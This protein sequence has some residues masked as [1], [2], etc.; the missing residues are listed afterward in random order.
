MRTKEAKEMKLPIFAERFGRL[1]DNMT[2][3]EFADFLGISRPTVGFY[4]N[5]ERI[6]D[7]S[8]LIKIAKK[9]N[10][11]TDWLLGI[12]DNKNADNR[13]IGEITGLNDEAIEFLSMCKM[14]ES[15]QI[16]AFASFLLENTECTPVEI[17][18][19]KSTNAFNMGEIKPIDIVND[20][21]TSESFFAF[22]QF[23]CNSIR[24]AQNFHESKHRNCS[25]DDNA[26]LNIKKYLPEGYT[27]L[28]F[29]NMSENEFFNSM[30]TIS[31]IALE[32]REKY[33]NDL[34]ENINRDIDD[35]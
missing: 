32:L 1:R 14:S 30:H 19:M 33:L 31:F 9:C 22:L 16:D 25:I 12:S 7:A 21:L 11:S 8:V 27:I 17:E 35:D 26:V 5:G 28:P 24:Y 15:K 4:E 13:T 23:F 34:L 3:A 18:Q 6:P 2:Q 10:V 29:F 20:V